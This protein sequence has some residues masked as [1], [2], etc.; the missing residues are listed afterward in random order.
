M[1]RDRIEYHRQGEN[2]LHDLCYRPT[3]SGKKW[4]P[5]QGK[6]LRRLTTF[7]GMSVGTSDGSRVTN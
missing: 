6:V 2:A 1:L 3:D 7:C 4:V 5:L